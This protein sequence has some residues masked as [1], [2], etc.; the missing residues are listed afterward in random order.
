MNLTQYANHG[1]WRTRNT[2][3]GLET[4]VLASQ[5]Q[6]VLL[7]VPNGVQWL[8]GGKTVPKAGPC[9]FIGLHLPTKRMVILDAKECGLV[10]RFDV[11]DGSKVKPHQIEELVRFGRAGA[12]AG[13]L[14]ERTRTRQLYWLPWQMLD[15]RPLP[16][17]YQWDELYEIGPSTHAV[18]WDKVLTAA[19]TAEKDG[20]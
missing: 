13:L 10:H 14:V 1:F 11:G 20:E 2:G 3:K 15:V 18:Q 8:P 17:S 4:L 9:D 7:K 19:A 12:I 16:P 6:V 5:G